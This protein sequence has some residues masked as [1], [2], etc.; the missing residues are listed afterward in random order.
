MLLLLTPARMSAGTP[1]EDKILLSD[2]DYDEEMGWYFT[3][4][5]QGSENYYTAYNLDIFF[6]EGMEV[7]SV[8]FPIDDSLYPQVK[9]GRVYV[10]THQFNY[11]FNENRR[12]RLACLSQQ[13]D[14]LTDVSGDLFDVFVNIDEDYFS[15]CFSPTPIIKVSGVALVT[16]IDRVTTQYDAQDYVC[17]PFSNGIP[18]DRTLPVN[19]SAANQFGTLILPFATDVPEGVKAYSC[20]ATEDDLLLLDEVER[21]EACMPYIL[22]AE[23]GYSGSISG[24]VD[25][26]ADYP[27]TDDNYAGGLLTGVLARS[28]VNTGYIMQNQGDGPKFY[29]AEGSAF[30]LPAG[31]CY[32]NSEDAGTKAFSFTED[33]TTTGILNVKKHLLDSNDVIYDLSGRRVA[34]PGKG[35]Y[36]K[37]GQ[38]VIWK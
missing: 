38:K 25:M 9:Q 10:K 30:L 23:N 17:R 3:V 2:L 36:V 13:L 12:L 21:L 22:Y 27:L 28:V 16:S 34:K 29:N 24:T 31:R 11:T 19:V 18:A 32:L 20:A 5:L 26:T 37:G 1:T 35:V 4:S 8:D 7:T 6:P 15:T 33:D 14:D